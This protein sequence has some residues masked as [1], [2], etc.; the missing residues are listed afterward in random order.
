MRNS[1]TIRNLSIA[2][3]ITGSKPLTQLPNQTQSNVRKIRCL[4]YYESRTTLN[5]LKYNMTNS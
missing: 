4:A 5:S 1:S 3:D 2:R